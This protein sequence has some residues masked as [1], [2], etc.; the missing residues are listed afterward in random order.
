[1]WFL[2]FLNLFGSTL[3]SSNLLSSRSFVFL[4]IELIFNITKI[5]SSSS[6]F[7]W[8]VTKIIKINYTLPVPLLLSRVWPVG[9][10]L[11]GLPFPLLLCL[12]CLASSLIL[13]GS[14]CW[15]AWE[16]DWVGWSDCFFN[17]LLSLW[18]KYKIR[19]YFF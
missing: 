10:S 4:L 19:F 11:F 14:S 2:R 15:T 3:F 16:V 12:I 7:S 8:S 9:T 13:L 5:S 17:Y 1:M 18:A 6:F